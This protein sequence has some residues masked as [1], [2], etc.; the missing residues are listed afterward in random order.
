MLGCPFSDTMFAIVVDLFLRDLRRRIDE[1]DH[2]FSRFCGDDVTVLCFNLLAMIHIDCFR[3][4][5]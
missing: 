2:G 4:N 3:E 1:K 5:S